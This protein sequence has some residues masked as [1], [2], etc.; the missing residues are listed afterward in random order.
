MASQGDPRVL[1]VLN[2]VLSFLFTL[3]VVSGL[4]FIDLLAFR[5]RTVGIGTAIL[6]LITH[7]VVMR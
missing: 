4:D 3:M 5:W 7:V 2:I 6:V 1:L